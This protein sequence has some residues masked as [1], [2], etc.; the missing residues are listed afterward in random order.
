[1]NLGDGVDIAKLAD[2]LSHRWGRRF[3]RNDERESGGHGSGCRAGG[4]DGT[5]VLGLLEF[6]G[7]IF[8]SEMLYRMVIKPFSIS[9]TDSEG[10]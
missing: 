7:V 9:V 5:D 4:R 6:F 10:K 8:S 3:S 2:E 1:L